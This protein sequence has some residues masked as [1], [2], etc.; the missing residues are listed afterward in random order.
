MDPATK[1][2]IIDEYV[3]GEKSVREI[4]SSVNQT[5]YAANAYIKRAKKAGIIPNV[6]KK[7]VTHK[8][9]PS[10]QIKEK[11]KVK[12]EP[13]PGTDVKCTPAKAKTCFYGC[14]RQ[15]Q[16]L[17]DYMTITGSARILVS[18]DPNHCSVYVE[19]KR[20]KKGKD[21]GKE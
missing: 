4:A 19:K 10:Y 14:K 15:S 1:K 21:D 13:K 5:F 8:S 18:P 20:E 17:C 16:G 11:P 7:A 6:R 3:K 2:Y 12:R 9:E